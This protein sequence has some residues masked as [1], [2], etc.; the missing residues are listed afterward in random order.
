MLAA[1][2]KRMSLYHRITEKLQFFTPDFY[3]ERYFKHLKNI[4]REN[5]SERNI[6]PELI[7]I[8]DYLPRN[9]VMIDIGAN[10]GS[11]LYQLERKL[12]PQN[13]FAFEPNRKLYM[14]LKR[15][16]PRVHIYPLALS[17]RNETADF[18]IPVIKGKA[19]DSRGTLQLNYRE[20]GEAKH[21]FQQVKVIKLDDWAGL[22]SM[23]K[24]DFIKIDVE[25]N[26]MHTLRGAKKVIKQYRPT[27]MVE[28]EQR[29]HQEP[30]QKMIS[31][32]ESWDYGTF[33]LNRKTFELEQLNENIIADLSQKVPGSKEEYINNMIF[34]PKQPKN[35][36]A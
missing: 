6:E 36:G 23:K 16:F 27:L 33:F 25:G 2:E 8:K 3:K 30:L 14:R 21:F 18:K 1:I 29:H 35:Y 22:E 12:S 7:W 4:S 34:I 26:E 9:A 17:D 24:I 31:E 10:V 5:Y 19:Y 15:I 11:F 20:N 13:I 32:I 28:M